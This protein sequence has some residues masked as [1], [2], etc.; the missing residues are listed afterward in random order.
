[1]KKVVLTIVVFV[2]VCTFALSQEININTAEDWTRALNS[3]AGGGNNKSYTL[4]IN[5][6][7]SIPGNIG[8]EVPNPY[9]FDPSNYSFG[10][11]NN[12]TVTLRGN[13]R[14]FLSSTGSLFRI[15]S[16]Q[17]LIINDEGLRFQGLLLRGRIKS[18]NSSPI[19][20]IRSGGNLNLNN[21]SIGSNTIDSSEGGGGVFVGADGVFIMSGGTIA[22]NDSIDYT[23]GG[24]VFVNYGGSFIMTGGTIYGN[25]SSRQGGGVFVQYGNFVK[26]G[27]TIFGKAPP[28]SN[29]PENTATYGC[30]VHYVTEDAYK[31]K[32]FYYCDTTLDETNNGNIRTADVLPS[33]NGQKV[34][35]WTR[36]TSR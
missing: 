36:G 3:I 14:V 24:G 32:Y 9:T 11:A 12:I 17:T 20:D 26:T 21:G 27:G 18:P 29:V 7:F 22:N 13:G 31:G 34:G 15:R 10:G 16:G 23:N 33:R 35:N 30:A 28:R 25:S 4:V 2:V 1:M 19:I 5:G 6:D 8:E